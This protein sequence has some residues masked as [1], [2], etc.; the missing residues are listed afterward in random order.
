MKIKLGNQREK[1]IPRKTDFEGRKTRKATLVFGKVIVEKN[2]SH[3]CPR[4]SADG[5]EAVI[6]SCKRP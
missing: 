1:K 3:Q 4:R 5:L 2:F 6:N